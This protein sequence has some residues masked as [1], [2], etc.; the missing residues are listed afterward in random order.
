MIEITSEE[1]ESIHQLAIDVLNIL[2]K[3]GFDAGE[4]R[5]E[6]TWRSEPPTQRQLSYLDHWEIPYE[7]GI[8]K[9][10]ASDLIEQHKEAQT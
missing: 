3:R 7:E 5:R 10:E 2:D 8:T 1:A 9:G 6:K 4:R